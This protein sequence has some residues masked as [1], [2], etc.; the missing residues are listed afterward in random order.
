MLIFNIYLLDLQRFSTFVEIFN[1][2]KRSEFVK[3]IFYNGKKEEWKYYSDKYGFRDGK[4]ANDYYRWFVRSGAVEGVWEPSSFM[5]DTISD[6]SILDI[7]VDIQQNEG[8]QNVEPVVPVGARVTKIWGKPGNYSYAYEFADKSD[9]DIRTQILNEFKNYSPRPVPYYGHKY[10]E[11]GITYLISLPDMHFGKTHIEKSIEDFLTAID[12]LLE[13]VKHY[14]INKIIL[15]IGNDL[16]HSEGISQST[17]KGTKMFDY[18]EWKEC[19][20]IIWKLLIDKIN[21]LSRISPIEIPIVLGNHS[22]AREYYLGCLLDAY[23][24]NNSNVTILNNTF[25]RKYI[26][27]GEVLLG[28]DH[29]ELKPYD[30]PLLMATEKPIEFS[31]STT[32]IMLCGHLHSQQ[33]YEIKG[34]HVRF[35]PSLCPSDEWHNKMGYSSQKAAQGYKFNNSGLLGYEE[36]RIK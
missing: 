19:F 22:E 3:E 1:M 8:I 33:N 29:G 25:P 20:N 23:Y 35:L 34:V 17:T 24:S 2:S 16:F 10:S 7:S 28:F 4:Q 13:R 26:Q 30:Y 9:T 14:H 21:M 27:F 18:V 12:E 36:F 5:S 31:K 6:D 32:R 15:P 11:T